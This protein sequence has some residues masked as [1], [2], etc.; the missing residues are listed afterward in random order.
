MH[1][2]ERLF[3]PTAT[4]PRPVALRRRRPA[5]A[6]RSVSRPR[7]RRSSRTCPRRRRPRSDLAPSVLTDSA[8]GQVLT[9]KSVHKDTDAVILC[10]VL[11]WKKVI[12]TQQLMVKYQYILNTIFHLH[13]MYFSWVWLNLF[14]CSV[15][16]KYPLPVKVLSYLWIHNLS[17]VRSVDTR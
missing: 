2:N 8:V 3:L 16:S 1:V 11:S 6:A 14:G 13:F 15:G 10:F 5:S 17:A 4:R 12:S 7:R 9:I